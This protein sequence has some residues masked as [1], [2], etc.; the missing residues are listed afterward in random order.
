MTSADAVRAD[1]P[2]K[3]EQ[4]PVS[5]PW[6][7]LLTVKA[8]VWLAIAFSAV[9]FFYPLAKSGIWDP[10][11]LN[12]ADLGRR[13]AINRFGASGLTLAGGENGMPRLGDLGRG[14]LPFTSIAAGFRL[15]GLHEWSGRLPLAVWGLLGVVALYWMLSRLVDK[16]TGIYGVAILATMPLYFTQARTMLGDIVTMAASSI[17]FAGLSVATF[18]RSESAGRRIPAIGMAV[19]IVGLFAG[20]MS[21]GLLIGVAMPALSVGIAWLITLS[22]AA[23]KPRL[24]ADTAGGASLVMGAVAA[25]VGTVIFVNAAPTPYSPLL[26]FTIIAQSKAPTCDL[27]IHYLGHSLFPWSALI[28]FAMGRLFY[29]PP[30]SDAQQNDSHAR[31]CLLV[32]SAIAVGVYTWVAYRAGYLAFGAPALFAAIAAICIRDFERSAPASL[33]VGVGVV[34]LTVLFLRDFQMFPEKGLSAFAI[35]GGTFPESFK[36]GAGDLIVLSSGIFS[37]IVLFSWL[38]KANKPWFNLKDYL[39]WPRALARAWDGILL[40]GLLAVEAALLVAAA[41][42]FVGMRFG[43]A[44]LKQMT[45][46]MG[47]QVRLYALNGFWVF[48]LEIGRAS[49]RERVSMFV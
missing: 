49:C 22:S 16:K 9:V 21:R 19:G 15:F 33:A 36:K 11:E 44:H 47:Q 7:R 13:I 10:H 45:V 40:V 39:S 3:P 1:P 24:A 41:V 32:G 34:I 29:S 6:R 43:G 18:D 37:G 17:A 31:L 26:G 2:A 46:Q 30:A 5:K 14:E 48:P 25:V 42:V 20:F 27:V 35:T 12:V 4:P 28:P 8:A 38:E 23:R